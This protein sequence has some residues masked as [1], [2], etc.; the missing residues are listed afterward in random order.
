MDLA[1]VYEGPV[2]P[3]HKKCSGS[4]KD[5]VSILCRFGNGFGKDSVGA[6]EDLIKL[7][8]W[9]AFNWD[10]VKTWQRDHSDFVE[11]W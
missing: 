9:C 11:L 4:D 8:H 6:G 1:R 10:L 3:L 7:R 2:Q 5:W